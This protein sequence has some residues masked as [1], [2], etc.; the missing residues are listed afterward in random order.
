MFW[1]KGWKSDSNSF[2]SLSGKNKSNIGWA[3]FFGDKSLFSTWYRWIRLTFQH[4]IFQI[5]IFWLRTVN[6]LRI[7]SH[8]LKKS[9]RENYIFCAVLLFRLWSGFLVWP[10]SLVTFTEEILNPFMTKAVTDWFLYDNGLR[11]ERV[12]G[13]LYF[14]CSATL[15]ILTEISGRSKLKVKSFQ[16]WKH[17]YIIQNLGLQ[18]FYSIKFIKY[19]FQTLPDLIMMPLN[20]KHL[21]VC[22]KLFNIHRCILLGGY[23][24]LIYFL[25][26][27]VFTWLH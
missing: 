15:A 19:I 3:I 20:G 10:E 23:A 1:Q 2:S 14:L 7:W 12:K 8:L 22:V 27:L 17:L 18:T 21:R 11:H 24:R 5:I 13:K 26:F 16:W 9:L 25:V 4:C 6:K